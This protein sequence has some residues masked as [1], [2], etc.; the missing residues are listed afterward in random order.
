[1]ERI[2]VSQNF[3]LDEFI[4]EALYNSMQD[5]ESLKNLI[6]PKMFL[7][8][9]RLRDFLG[10]PLTINNWASG[11]VRQWSGLRTSSSPYYSVTSMHSFGKALDIISTRMSAEAMRTRINYNYH[12]FRDVISRVEADVNWLHIDCKVTNDYDL[13]FF[14]A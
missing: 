1:M 10:V 4:D 11:G 5:K 13:V 14:K 6:D 3:Y 8:A 2:K 12:L 9:Q 7:A